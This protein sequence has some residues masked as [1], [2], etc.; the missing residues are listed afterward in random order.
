[1][2]T[3]TPTPIKLFSLPSALVLVL[4]IIGGILEYLN[5]NTFGFPPAWH[6]AVTY[7]I[8]LVT[9][10]GVSIPV[11]KQL[12]LDIDHLLHITPAAAVGIASVAYAIAAA[13]GT[14]DV[15]GVLKGVLLGVVAFITS[16]FGPG[17]ETL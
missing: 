17:G 2:A 1:M 14:F 11:G 13:I 10:F 3:P 8:L 12:G 9:M 4:A 7:G 6:H 15:S 16:I 5:Q